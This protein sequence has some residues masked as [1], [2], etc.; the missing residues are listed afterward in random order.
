[1]VKRFTQEKCMRWRMPHPSSSHLYS[2][3]CVEEE[4]SE[5][6]GSKLDRL[7][8]GVKGLEPAR[9]AVSPPNGTRS[10]RLRRG[11]VA[12]GYDLIPPN[13]PRISALPR[14]G[15]LSRA[16]P[17][18]RV[19]SMQLGHLSPHPRRRSFLVQAAFRQKRDSVQYNPLGNE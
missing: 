2:S 14:S 7:W 8:G 16:S 3:K 19:Q 5:V 12:S 4:F 6:R 10:P 9:G 13:Y 11:S 1:M 17:G 15:N 18:L